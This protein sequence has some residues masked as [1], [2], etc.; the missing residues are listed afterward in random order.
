MKAVV[1]GR[2]GA[3]DVFAL[4][5]LDRPSPKSGEVLIKVAAASLHAG[6]YLL[7]TG[8]PYVMRLGTG[9][10]RPRKLVPGFDVSGHVEQVGSDVTDFVPG[11]EVF[12][13]CQGSCAEYVCAAEKELAHK[14]VN[15]SLAESATLAISGVTG[16]IGIRD[17]GRVKFGQR[18][19]INGA[20][21]G[22][23][24]YAV[25]VAKALGAV[26][27]GVCSSRNVETVKSIGADHVI[28]YT[29]QDL[30]HGDAR[31]DLIMDNVGNLSLP[32]VKGVLEPDGKY[33]PNSG[34]SEGRWFGAF[35]RMLKAGLTSVFVGQQGR[36]F[37]AP[38]K[39]TYLLELKELVE[40]GHVKPVIENTYSLSETAQAMAAVGAGHVCGKVLINIE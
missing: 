4:R 3:E 5:E 24:T 1:Q 9:L 21:G 16:M 7:A 32:A 34:R 37:F 35:G 39:K 28:D 15:L 29:Q 19:L 31:Y 2:Y 14:P 30:T 40:A 12:G 23:G 6:D 26:V 10:R 17:A 13:Q 20:S 36:P 18:V 8:T 25:Q 38:V 27:T 33:I 11:D 22:V